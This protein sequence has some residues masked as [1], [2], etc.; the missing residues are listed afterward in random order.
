MGMLY[1][2]TCNLIV[3]TL[4]LMIPPIPSNAAEMQ[5]P[6]HAR[7]RSIYWPEEDSVRRLPGNGVS[8]CVNLYVIQQER[9]LRCNLE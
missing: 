8:S 2:F 5:F 4:Q 1:P 6:P 9:A 7:I 3:Y